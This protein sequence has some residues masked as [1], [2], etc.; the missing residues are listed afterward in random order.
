MA[1]VP[2][3]Y[4]TTDGQ[5]RRIA[6][7]LASRLRESGLTSAAIDLSDPDVREVDWT[8]VK[9]VMLGASVR[10]GRHQRSAEAFVR[11]HREELN[12][13]PSAFFSVSLSAASSNPAEV[14]TVEQ[15]A[16]QFCAAGGWTP[17]KVV[18]LAGR[19]AYTQYGFVTRWMM[20][21][22]ARKEGGPTDT[23][24]DHELTKW[25]EVDWLADAMAALVRERADAAGHPPLAEMGAHARGA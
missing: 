3:F 15:I 22:I 20:R 1:D 17:A 16:K 23:S 25:D 5:T 8:R 2:V 24:R 4:A 7:R 18:C 6:E 13:R 19:L 10:A 12:A 9:G 11:R 14:A 21:R